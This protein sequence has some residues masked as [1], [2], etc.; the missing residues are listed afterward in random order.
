MP[1]RSRGHKESRRGGGMPTEEISGGRVSRRGPKV[2]ERL[3]TMI[4]TIV[5]ARRGC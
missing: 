3:E 2:G 4:E 1:R 5:A